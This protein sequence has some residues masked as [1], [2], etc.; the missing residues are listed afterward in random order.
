MLIPWKASIFLQKELWP[1]EMAAGSSSAHL[2][3]DL[4]TF[5]STTSCFLVLLI[6]KDSLIYTG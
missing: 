1:E 2:G 5:S 4:L 6:L 3:K